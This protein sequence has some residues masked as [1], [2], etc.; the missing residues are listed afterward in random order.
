MKSLKNENMTEEQQDDLDTY[1]AL[2]TFAGSEGGKVLIENLLKDV[3]NT[4]GI[5]ENQYKTLS[6][7]ELIAHCAALGEKLSLVRTLTRAD[8][9]IKDLTKLIEDTLAE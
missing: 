1:T 5:L 9:N 3:T 8:K 2:K 4:V 6:H 7:I